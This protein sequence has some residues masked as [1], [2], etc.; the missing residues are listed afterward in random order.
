MYS[1]TMHVL[2]T[3][4]SLPFDFEAELAG[5][6]PQLRYFA[7]SLTGSMHDAEEVIQNANRIALEKAGEFEVGTNLKAWLFK[8]ASLQAKSFHRNQSRK[9]GYEIVDDELL[10]FLSGDPEPEDAFENERAALLSCLEQL[11]PAHQE[12]IT[13]RY[14]HGRKVSE[15]ALEHEILPNALAQKLFRIRNRLADCIQSRLQES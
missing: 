10:E 7:L 3:S 14:V 9:R 8:I 5:L 15:L 6:Q 2:R 1:H 4:D 12:L 13:S 11:R